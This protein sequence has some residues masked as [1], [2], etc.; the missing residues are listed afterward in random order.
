MPDLKTELHINMLNNAKNQYSSQRYYGEQ[1]GDPEKD[2]KLNYIKENFILPNTNEETVALE[3]GCGGG[4]WTQYLMNCK[5]IYVVDYYYEMFYELDRFI[6]SSKIIKVKNNGN[7][8]PNIPQNSIDFLFSF[9]TFV[10]LDIDII[11]EY[12][13]NI[14]QIMKPESKIFIQYSNKYKEKARQNKGFSINN[15]KI[16]ESITYFLGYEILDFYDELEHSSCFLL[17][18]PKITLD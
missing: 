18:P 12:M 17:S 7:D 14:A 11:F 2:T 15:H 9:G 6:Q 16:M 1:W 4:R 8:F 3:I 10:H 13:S 5:K